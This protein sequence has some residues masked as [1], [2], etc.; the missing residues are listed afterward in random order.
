LKRHL[1]FIAKREYGGVVLGIVEI[2]AVDVRM[3]LPTQLLY[4]YLH[5]RERSPLTRL[6][7]EVLAHPAARRAG[8]RSSIAEPAGAGPGMTENSAVRAVRRKSRRLGWAGYGTCAIMVLCI[9]P[10]S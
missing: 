5:E 4:G 1:L 3:A 6:Q 9:A 2:L 8:G 7:R 10:P